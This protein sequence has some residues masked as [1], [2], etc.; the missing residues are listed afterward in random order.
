MVSESCLMRGAKDLVALQNVVHCNKAIMLALDTVVAV[1]AV[2]SSRY[3]LTRSSRSKVSDISCSYFTWL[4]PRPMVSQI[5]DG[6]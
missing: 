1:N 2:Q 5:W 6:C 4:S 3:L